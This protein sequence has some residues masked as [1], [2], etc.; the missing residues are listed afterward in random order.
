MAKPQAAQTTV[1]A[2][3]VKTEPKGKRTVIIACKFNTGVVL[4]L[5]RKTDYVEEGLNGS[6]KRERWD[7]FGE[8]YTVR[9][10]AIAA[11]NVL[12]PKGMKRPSLEGGYALTPGIPAD[13][14]AE[15]LVQNKDNPIVVNGMIFAHESR[16]QVEG[17]AADREEL[18]SGFEPIVPDS[19]PRIPKSARPEVDP[20]KT[21]TRA[22]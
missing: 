19:D 8:T 7:K 4:Q 2:P 22:A 12:L 18:R 17:M 21:A 5:C 6:R 1:E 16:D 11:D 10:P 3:A 15:W 14:W 13:F 9:G 20:I